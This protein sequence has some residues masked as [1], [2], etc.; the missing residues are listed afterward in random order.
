[1]TGQDDD[2]AVGVLVLAQDR[3]APCDLA[4]RPQRAQA[5]PVAGL[6]AVEELR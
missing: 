3:L 6:E 2:D 4:H 5:L 1:V